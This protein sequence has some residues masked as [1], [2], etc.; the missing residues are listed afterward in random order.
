MH[1]QIRCF[2]I[3]LW[4]N[5]WSDISES[6]CSNKANSDYRK[7]QAQPFHE[8]F[9]PVLDTTQTAA[10][11]KCLC[12]SS[13]SVSLICVTD[14]A[15]CSLNSKHAL[16]T[17]TTLLIW[18][19][20]LFSPLKNP[21]FHWSNKKSGKNFLH[22]KSKTGAA[23]ERKKKKTGWSWRNVRSCSSWKYQSNKK[24]S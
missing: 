2:R 5:S 20:G 1:F 14:L 3:H 15:N 21:Q 7:L 11:V 16:V 17:I 6:T 23:A 9:M 10:N 18:H 8:F 12:Y 13:S 19:R 24:K 22:S 4:L